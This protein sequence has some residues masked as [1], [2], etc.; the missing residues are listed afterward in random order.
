MDGILYGRFNVGRE[1]END[2]I[3]E[4]ESVQSLM[5]ARR[6]FRWFGSVPSILALYR[7][8]KTDSC[9]WV[10][11]LSLSL[12]HHTTTIIIIILSLSLSLSLSLYISLSLS[13]THHKHHI[14]KTGREECHTLHLKQNLH[15]P[16]PFDR[17]LSILYPSQVDDE[18]HAGAKYETSRSR[19]FVWH[20]YVSL[21]R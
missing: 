21:W 13:L 18:T 12:S 14:I 15:G 4:L 16:V 9:A 10:R 7:L 8:V 1:P 5:N 19:F 6:A 2:Q 11:S 17:S 3:E 20:R